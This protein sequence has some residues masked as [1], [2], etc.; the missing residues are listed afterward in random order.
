MNAEWISAKQCLP[1]LAD[2]EQ[3]RL[4]LIGGEEGILAHTLKGG[5]SNY[6]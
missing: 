4:G 5:I 6:R 1:K 3:G 2:R